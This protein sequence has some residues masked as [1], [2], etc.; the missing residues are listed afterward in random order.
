MY[1]TDLNN[2]PNNLRYLDEDNLIEYIFIGI[3]SPLSVDQKRKL[4]ARHGKP[5]RTP[6]S[7]KIEAEGYTINVGPPAFE[8]QIIYRVPDDE[9]VAEPN[10]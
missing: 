5:R 2:D 8:M 10:A 9:P 4:I 1:I 6:L 7:A 3:H